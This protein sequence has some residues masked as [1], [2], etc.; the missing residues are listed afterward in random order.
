MYFINSPKDNGLSNLLFTSAIT[1]YLHVHDEEFTK[2]NL[3]SSH[4]LKIELI[5]PLQICDQCTC[6]C[7][8]KEYLY[9]IQSKCTGQ[10]LQ[11][12]CYLIFH[13]FQDWVLHHLLP[14]TSFP[15]ISNA[16]SC[17]S[18]RIFFN[19]L[20]EFILIYVFIL[21]FQQDL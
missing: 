14:Q 19:C 3:L 17:A 9:L 13:R 4:R 10:T 15:N 1:I 2:N 16:F 12:I 21:L 20:C 5:F 18:R 6:D 7:A 8:W 11:T